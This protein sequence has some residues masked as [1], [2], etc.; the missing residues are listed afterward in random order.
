M[1]YGVSQSGPMDMARFRLATALAGNTAVAFEVSVAGAAFVA[2]GTVR[3]GIAAPGFQVR[4]DEGEPLVSPLRLSLADG[5]RLA[6]TPGAAG[7]WGYVAVAGLDPGPPVLGSFATNARTGLGA[8]DLS[9]PFAAAPAAPAPPEP[10]LD[11]VED[12]G[13][14]ALLPGPQHHLFAQEV[15]ERI[16]AEPFRLTER[17]DRMGYLLDGPRIE[18][19]THD[20]ISDGIVEGA[21]QVPGSGQPF[22]LCADRAPTGGYPKIA[23]VARA[24]RPRLVQRRPG[25]AVTFRWEDEETARGRW[26]ALLAA[27]SRPAPRARESFAPE[28]LAGRNLVDGVWSGADDDTA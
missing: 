8:R 5:A 14:V 11:P 28:F 18:A 7:M 23:I 9:R 16:A 3:V 24:D 20:I 13:P 2:E 4:L 26:R 22:I 19:A 27:V 17:V 12:E 1:R 6:L 25:D 15:R 10:F 21:M